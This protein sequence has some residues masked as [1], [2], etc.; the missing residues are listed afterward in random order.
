MIVA[1]TKWRNRITRVE[2]NTARIFMKYRYSR[3]AR[4]V[5]RQ[6][7]RRNRYA[8][9]ILG[10]WYRYNK[11]RKFDPNLTHFPRGYSY[12]DY[13][14]NYCNIFVFDAIW[15]AGKHFYNPNGHY[16]GPRQVYEETVPGLKAISWR[17]ASKG[18]IFASPGHVGLVDYRINRRKF[19]T[20]EWGNNFKPEQ[21]YYRNW[22]FRR[23]V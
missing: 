6:A 2:M 1:S 11:I 23:V 10:I 15:N 19:M 7:R 17:Q 5:R 16:P 14:M 9:K 20:L 13:N 12:I 22:R 18:D 21:R 3:L 4:T 8:R